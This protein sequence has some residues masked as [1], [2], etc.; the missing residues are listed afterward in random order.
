[1][2]FNHLLLILGMLLPISFSATANAN[3]IQAAVTKT[4][5]NNQAVKPQ[6]TL[7]IK[8][9]ACVVKRA[10]ENCQMTITAQWQSTTPIDA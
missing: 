6:V 8:P 2:R 9:L 5:K 4:Q 7:A 3:N 10:G 1:M